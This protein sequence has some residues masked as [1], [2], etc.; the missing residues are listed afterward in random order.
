MGEGVRT[1]QEG[2]FFKSGLEEA[3]GVAIGCFV[4][5]VDAAE[6]VPWAQVASRRTVVP[7]GDLMVS[8]EADDIPGIGVLGVS[9]CLAGTADPPHN[10][11]ASDP[12]SSS[13]DEE[14]DS[15]FEMSEGVRRSI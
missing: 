10:P 4:V 9:T 5:G 3:G 8:C 14:L 12:L 11:K 2:F 15:V 1:A 13:S 7:A 6:S